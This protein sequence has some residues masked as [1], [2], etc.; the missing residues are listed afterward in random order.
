ML[1]LLVL[2]VVGPFGTYFI[3]DLCYNSSVPCSFTVPSLVPLPAPVAAVAC[4]DFHTVVLCADGSVLT[5]GLNASGQL[6]R[7][8]GRARGKQLKRKM[9][10]CGHVEF[11]EIG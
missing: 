2:V 1:L 6:G 3:A 8:F 10:R 7:A 11:Q 4:G 5:M 9:L